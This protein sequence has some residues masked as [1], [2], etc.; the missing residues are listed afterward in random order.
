MKEKLLQQLTNFG[1]P[2]IEV[3]DGNFENRGEGILTHRHEGVDLKT[4]CPGDAEEPLC[5]A[6]WHRP[7]NL[8]TKPKGKTVMLRF[9]GKEHSERKID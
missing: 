9:D 5:R 1:Q 4:L 2:V 8:T 7:V 3:V 6:L